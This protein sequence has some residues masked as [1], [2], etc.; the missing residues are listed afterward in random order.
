[1]KDCVPATGVLD[2]ELGGVSG[3][4]TLCPNPPSPPC[5]IYTTTIKHSYSKSQNL[6]IVDATSVAHVPHCN[7]F[8]Q[9]ANNIRHCST[10]TKTLSEPNGCEHQLFSYT[11]AI[12]PR[13]AVKHRDSSFSRH[14]QEDSRDGRGVDLV[15]FGLM[16]LNHLI[17]LGQP[18]PNLT[19]DAMRLL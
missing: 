18:R 11:F 13:P 14:W 10:T 3:S 1:M 7:A 9:S 8:S 5:L 12:W 4:L 19:I 16:L 2:L 17:S 15:S 6:G